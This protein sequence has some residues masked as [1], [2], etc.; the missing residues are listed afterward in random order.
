MRTEVP[1]IGFVLGVEGGGEEEEKGQGDEETGRPGEAW[2]HGGMGAW[3]I[4]AE[5]QDF[6]LTSL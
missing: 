5:F 3:K 6:H 2:R 1:D 4:K